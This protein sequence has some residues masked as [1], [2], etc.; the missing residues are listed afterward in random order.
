MSKWHVNR[1]RMH[2]MSTQSEHEAKKGIEISAINAEDATK[3]LQRRLKAVQ[4]E[5][6]RLEAAKVVSQETMRLEVSI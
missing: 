4:D 1:E 5:V 2:M 3:E 6:D